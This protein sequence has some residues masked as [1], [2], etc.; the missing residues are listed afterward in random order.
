[1]IGRIV[2]V[3]V[4]MVVRLDLCC[5]VLG[6]RGNLLEEMMHP[7]RCGNGEKKPKCRG[8]AKVQAAFYFGSG[9]HRFKDILVRPA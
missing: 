1:M 4:D 9:C 7:M 3:A 2:I 6:R 8:N 5:R